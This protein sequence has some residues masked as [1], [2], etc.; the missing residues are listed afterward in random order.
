MTC[1]RAE[2]AHPCQTEIMETPRKPEPLTPLEKEE[3]PSTNAYSGD[4]PQYTSVYIPKAIEK[5]AAKLIGHKLEKPTPLPQ[6]EE[7]H[8]S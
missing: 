6:R 5:H 8:S 1:I 2:P 7:G 4:Y 3:A